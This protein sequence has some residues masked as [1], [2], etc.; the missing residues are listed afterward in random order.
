[1]K[2][3]NM[4]VMAALAGLLVSAG[5]RAED[6]KPVCGDFGGLKLCAQP[7]TAPAPG[8]GA[9]VTCQVPG[10]GGALQPL[11][12]LLYQNQTK[13][14]DIAITYAATDTKPEAQRKALEGLR[15]ALEAGRAEAE[16]QKL[17]SGHYHMDIAAYRYGMAL[18]RKSVAA[19]PS[20]KK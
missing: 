4:A 10:T 5:A 11:R 15:A 13:G 20:V 14:T 18:Y 12:E 8:C 3:L 9:G 19:L 17:T 1:M 2:K 16:S 7:G 6:A